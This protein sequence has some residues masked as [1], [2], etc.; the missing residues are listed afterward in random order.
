MGTPDELLAASTVTPKDRLFVRNNFDVPG[1]M[2]LEARPLAGWTIE[3]AGLASGP[4]KLAAESLADMEQVEHEFVLQCSGNSRSLYSKI[5]P[6]E[7]TQWGR[8]GIGNVRMAG[9]PLARV[10]ETLGLKLNPRARYLTAEGHDAPAAAGKPD[11]E[12]SIPLE[13]A[14]ERS[15]LALRLGE[16][17]LPAIHGGPVRLVTPGYYATM[18]VKWLTRL[19]FDSAETSNHFQIPQYR[20]PKR[21]IAPGSKFDFTFDNSD[22]NWDL[23]IASRIFAPADGARVPAGKVELS[24]VAWNDGQAPLTAVEISTDEGRSWRATEW[25]K[26]ASPF[27]WTPWRATVELPPGRATVLCRAIDA[28][29]RTQPPDGTTTWNPHGYTWNAV[30]RV[31]V[32]VSG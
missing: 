6:T 29:G 28:L 18:N 32:E 21:P 20:T 19:R 2:S 7:G 12:H 1:F 11:F 26:A 23:R 15:F 24:G 13:V 4:T 22:P 9:V 3:F 30:D 14:L 27:A 10:V 8:G 31:T 16:E 25:A 17:P 5:A